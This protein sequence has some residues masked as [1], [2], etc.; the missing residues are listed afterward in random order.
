MIDSPKLAT[1]RAKIAGLKGDRKSLERE[2]PDRDEAA[3][4]LQSLAET[5][6]DHGRSLLQPSGLRYGK[7]PR[8][9]FQWRPEDFFDVILAL[10]PSAP[11]K[12]SEIANRDH[13]GQGIT[14]ADRRQ[15]L[16]KIDA[17]LLA[18]EIEE[19]R[20]IRA[21]PGTLRRRD[22]NPAVVLAPQL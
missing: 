21:A 7:L 12:L 15:R 18:L 9:I 17:D 13:P 2:L 1:V 5:R 4:K 22:A 11:R 10:D 3:A 16:K 8:D 6:A 14:D 19:E 20:A